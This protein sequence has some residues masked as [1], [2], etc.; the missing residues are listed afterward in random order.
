MH[1]DA[2]STGT[3]GAVNVGRGALCGMVAPLGI[4]ADAMFLRGD[5]NMGTRVG[6]Q[7]VSSFYGGVTIGVGRW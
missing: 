3:G 7:P 2:G 1:I 5:A 4:C 6:F